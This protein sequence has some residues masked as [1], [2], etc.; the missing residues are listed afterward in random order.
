MHFNHNQVHMAIHMVRMAVL[1]VVEIP[2]I[3]APSR[4]STV[5]NR[6][7]IVVMVI[8]NNN[9][10]NT[11][12]LVL[13]VMDNGVATVAADIIEKKIYKFIKFQLV[14]CVYKWKI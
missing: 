6:T 7:A 8:I 12:R 14:M 1:R 2:I 13:A 11:G 5:H 4:V 10:N 9:G 3:T